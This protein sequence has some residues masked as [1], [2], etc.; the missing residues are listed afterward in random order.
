MQCLRERMQSPVAA[1][2][3]LERTEI[4][5]PVRGAYVWMLDRSPIYVG[6]AN[7]LRKRIAQH[8][9]ADP[10]GAN[11]AVRVAAR[12]LG[13]SLRVVKRQASFGSAFLDARS[14]LRAGDIAYL[15]IEN[16]LE[17][18]LFEP[19]CAMELDT[20]TY[21]FFDTLQIVSPKPR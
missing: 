8:M 20:I 4:I 7:N 15:E 18:Y 6:I 10:S 13:C 14:R 16:S 21:N 12:A 2:N 11:L 3:I 19:Y 9:L 5:P 1:S 17:L